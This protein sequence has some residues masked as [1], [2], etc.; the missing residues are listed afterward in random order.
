MDINNRFR[1]YVSQNI[2]ATLGISLY[3]LADVFFIAQAVGSD[4]VTALNLVLPLYSLIFGLGQM[5][6]VGSA[7][8]F[9]LEKDTG[10]ASGNVWFSNALICAVIVS[11]PFIIVGIF[12]AGPLVSL[13][14]GDEII[15]AVGEPY[16]RI[17][18]IFAPL[19]M[20]NYICNAF[21]R[22]DGSPFIAM[23][24]TLFSSLFNI[25]FDYVLMFPLGMGMAGAAL[26][27]ACSPIVGILICFFHFR[28]DK[29]TLRFKIV[30]PDFKRLIRGCQLGIS[31]F[32][33]EMSSGVTTAVFNFLILGLTGNTGVA[34][35]GIVANL[36]LVVTAVFNGIAQGSQP[37]VSECRS[38]DDMAGVKSLLKKSY[39]LS[40]IVAVIVIAVMWLFAEPIASVFNKSA[41]ETLAALAADGLHFYMIGFLFAG[42]NIIGTMFLSA[43]GKAVPAFAASIL[44]GFVMISLCAVVMAAMFGMNGV[45]LS[46]P[47]SEALTLIVTLIGIKS[48][49]GKKD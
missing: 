8:R 49:S 27:T 2:L 3:V 42:L 23:A 35:Y 5:M 18:M 30:M 29:C 37:L 11:I 39:A 31:S 1:K 6:G 22:N 38:T 9:A 26:A 12:W 32:V 34:A 10:R 36:A 40:V 46:F 33:G 17:F 44:R 48:I 20:W 47:A 4:G 41:D 45:W 43:L 25:V 15:T 28:S 7:I 13:M 21:V 19:F 16:T 14:G 24:A